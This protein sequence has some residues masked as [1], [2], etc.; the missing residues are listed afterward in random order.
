MTLIQL[1][2][3]VSADQLLRAVAQL[4]PP[5][6]ERFLAGVRQLPPSSPKARRLSRRESELLWQINQGLPAATQRRYDELIEKRRDET[7]T[8]E[9]Y[10]QLL[11]LT[12]QAE[13]WD[14]KRLEC[15][16]ELATL[17][18][19]PLTALLAELEIQAPQ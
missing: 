4:P 1:E 14:V 11:Q 8:D 10:Q 18:R 15:L 12:D 2:A 13:A 7:L 9:E 19:L 6:F 3:Q 17:R 16:T 5:E